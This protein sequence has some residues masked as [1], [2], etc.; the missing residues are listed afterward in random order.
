MTKI[1]RHC[2]GTRTFLELS[3][4]KFHSIEVVVY[5]CRQDLHWW[6]NDVSSHQSQVFRILSR[7][8]LPNECREEILT[9]KQELNRF[10]FQGCK[11][12]RTAVI[13]E[14]NKSNNRTSFKRR[15]H[16]TNDGNHKTDKKSAEGSKPVPFNKKVATLHPKK[17]CISENEKDSSI[18]KDITMFFGETIQFTYKVE[19]NS[20]KQGVCLLYNPIRDKDDAYG[21]NSHAEKKGATKCQEKTKK[22][23]TFVQREKLS[24]RLLIWCYKFDGENPTCPSDVD[25]GFPRP[26]LIPMSSLFC[27]ERTKEKIHD[28]E[29]K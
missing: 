9:Y 8:I 10:N 15:P 6:N 16:A 2:Y 27:P 26:A 11:R 19:D 21:G 12:K 24:K 29:T 28:K 3:V 25:G 18:S 13:G 7:E 5:L 1:A 14:N 4:G 23:A 20:D 22:L 17:N